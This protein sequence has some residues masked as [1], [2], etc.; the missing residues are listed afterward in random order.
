MAQGKLFVVSGPSAVGKSTVVERVLQL[1]DTISRIVTCTSRG[2]R[3]NEQDGVDYFF[4]SKEFFAEQ[5]AQDA[6]IEFSEVY[7]NYYGVLFSTVQQAIAEGTTSIL[8]INWEGF[9]KI[10]LKLQERVHGIFIQPPSIQDL[11]DRMINRSTESAQDMQNRLA[12]AELDISHAEMFDHSVVNRE[13]EQAAVEILD[14]INK[15]RAQ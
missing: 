1:D 6:F 8:V 14:F 13:I 7:G 4:F 3:S 5:I 15:V 11:A 2:I 10:K 9:C 12:Q